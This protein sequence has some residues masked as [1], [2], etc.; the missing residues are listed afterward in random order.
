MLDELNDLV[1]RD[2]VG[3]RVIVAAEVAAAAPRTVNWLRSIGTEDVLVVAGASGVGDLPD[4]EIVYVEPAPNLGRT[5]I[6]AGLRHYLRALERPSSEVQAA[7][8]GF[9]PAGRAIVLAPPIA[10]G[11]TAFGR[12][13]WGARRREWSALEDKTLADAIW[14]RAGVPRE[15]SAVV[16]VSDARAAVQRL[17]LGMG[18]VWAADNREGWHGGGDYTRWVPEPAD[19]DEATGWFAERADRVR[20]MPFLDGIPCSIHGFVTPEAVAAFRPVEMVILRHAH[21]PQFVYA[22]LA[23]M[24]DPDPADREQM[25]V[26]ARRVGTL[27]RD[28]VG[29]RG[30]FSIDGVMTADGFRPT[31]L[32]PRASVGFLT[33]AAAVEGLQAMALARAHV[34]G[35]VDVDAARLEEHIVAAADAHRSARLGLPLPDVLDQPRTASVRLESGGAVMNHEDPT[36]VIEAGSATVGCYVTIDIDVSR[37]E[38]GASVAPAAAA[39]ADLIRTEWGLSVPPTVPA[40]DVRAAALSGTWPG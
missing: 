24:W 31:E 21:E 13:V 25:R 6:M 16:P 8:D 4:C 11:V 9:D 19:A 18:T 5:T 37:L 29:Y 14:D 35:R 27:L 3:R 17:D 15:S 12:P 23:T 39:I 28:D 26:A 20:V 22:R 34:E 2:Y 33:Q 30:P 10:T 1:T 40:P 38:R 32:N 36:A 7:V